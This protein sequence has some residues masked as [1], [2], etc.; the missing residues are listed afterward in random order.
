MIVVMTVYIFRRGGRQPGEGKWFISRQR[1][2]D[3]TRFRMC[4]LFTG[5][6]RRWNDGKGAE[7]VGRLKR[8]DVLR[9]R[10]DWHLHKII[11]ANRAASGRAMVVILRVVPELENILLCYFY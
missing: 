4:W 10:N 1:F 5:L 6:E 3:V 8:I 2:R 7:E 11:C 9:R